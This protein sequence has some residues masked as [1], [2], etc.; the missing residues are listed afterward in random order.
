MERRKQQNSCTFDVKGMCNKLNECL[1]DNPLSMFGQTCF[2][3]FPNH[4]LE[5]D[6]EYIQLNTSYAF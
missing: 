3:L 6:T 5:K 1:I 2:R 4:D